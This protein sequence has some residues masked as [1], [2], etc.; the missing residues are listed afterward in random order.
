M[1]EQAAFPGIK[2]PNAFFRVVL[3]TGLL[4]G[5]LDAIAASVQ[6]YIKTGRNPITIFRYIASA[7]FGKKAYEGSYYGMAAW[8]LFF[9]FLIAMSFTLFFFLVY[10]AIIRLAKNKYVVGVLFGIFT[11][12]VMNLLVVPLSLLTKSPFNLSNAL[13]GAGILILAIGLPV[14]LMADNYYKKKYLFN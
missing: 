4:A 10:P 11:W 6:F 8:G 7:A 9:H 5:T 1:S 14:S 3:T 12:L 13:T 2:N